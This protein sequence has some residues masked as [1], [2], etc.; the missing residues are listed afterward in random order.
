MPD[1]SG[2]GGAIGESSANGAGKPSLIQS[3][4]STNQCR[5]LLPPTPYSVLRCKLESGLDFRVASPPTYSPGESNETFHGNSN[6]ELARRLA[7]GTVAPL[8]KNND[9]PVRTAGRLQAGL[10]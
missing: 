1:S 6:T 5:T 9:A 4:R 10:P 8:V 2:A 7:G 3:K